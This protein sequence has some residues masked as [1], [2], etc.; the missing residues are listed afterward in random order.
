[1]A[2]TGG[3]SIHA[4]DDGGVLLRAK[5]PAE[6]TLLRSSWGRPATGISVPEWKAFD[7][8]RSYAGVTRSCQKAKGAT[9]STTAASSTSSTPPAAPDSPIHSCVRMEPTDND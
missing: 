3:I 8:K 6:V 1:M 9:R 7:S 5:C 2:A 4:K